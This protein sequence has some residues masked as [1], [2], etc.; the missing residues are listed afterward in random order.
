ML[1]A[2]TAKFHTEDGDVSSLSK[3]EMKTARLNYMQ[4][5]IYSQYDNFR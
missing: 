3:Q 5:K 2:G 4:M 1:L